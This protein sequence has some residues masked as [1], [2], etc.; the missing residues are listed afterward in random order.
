MLS[1]CDLFEQKKE[2]R[3]KKEEE[4]EEGKRK[5][6]RRSNR[7]GVAAGANYFSKQIGSWLGP[8]LGIQLGRL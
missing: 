2:K 7:V 8:L 6:G 1:A 4:K 3:R 5:L